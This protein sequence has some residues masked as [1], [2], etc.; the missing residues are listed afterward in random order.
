MCVLRERGQG[1]EAEALRRDVLDSQLAR[2][3]ESSADPAA[4]DQRFES[5][6]ATEV[7]RVATASVLAELLA[8]LLRDRLPVPSPA[9]SAAGAAPRPTNVPP[10][11]PKRAPRPAAGGIAD[12]IDEMIAHERDAK[13]SAA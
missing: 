3:R 11:A 10:P 9:V 4:I 7:D 6:L 13:H 5:V 8:P 1:E 2:L 12:F